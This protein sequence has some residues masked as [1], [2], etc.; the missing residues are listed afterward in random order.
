MRR[1]EFFFSCTSSVPLGEA[2]GPG[3]SAKAGNY[4][5]WQT[6]ALSWSC[7]PIRPHSSSTACRLNTLKSLSGL[8]KPHLAPLVMVITPQWPLLYCSALSMSVTT[9]PNTDGWEVQTHTAACWYMKLSTQIWRSFSSVGT[10]KWKELL[11]CIQNKLP[12]TRLDN[13]GC[14]RQNF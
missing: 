3:T 6:W 14:C 5:C 13:N 2:P 10:N 1:D 11:Q 4:Q 8:P 7:F 9:Y 12:C